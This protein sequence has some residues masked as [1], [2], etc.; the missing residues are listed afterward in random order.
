MHA[1]G[2][3]RLAKNEGSRRPPTS[4]GEIGRSYEESTWSR[5]AALFS[6]K[7]NPARR[8]MRMQQQLLQKQQQ[9]QQHQKQCSINTCSINRSRIVTAAVAATQTAAAAASPTAGAAT[10]K[11]AA[12][13]MGDSVGMGY[14]YLLRP[15]KEK[16]DISSLMNRL[17][18]RLLACLLTCL[19]TFLLTHLLTCPIPT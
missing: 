16:D 18:T 4:G 2:I 14:P 10:S 3:E 8:V 17:L 6:P 7:A 1:K 13:A 12:S 11:A 9:Q 5:K 15:L 19:M